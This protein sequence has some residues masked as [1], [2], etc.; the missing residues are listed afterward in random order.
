[1]FDSGENSD[2]IVQCCH[3]TWKLDRLILCAGSDYSKTALQGDRFQVLYP[4]DKFPAYSADV[5]KEGVTGSIRPQEDDPWPTGQLLRF[6]YTHDYQVDIGDCQT[7]DRRCPLSAHARMYAM[8][9][10]HQAPLLKDLAQ[11][12][13]VPVSKGLAITA[14]PYIADAIR[15][16]FTSTLPSDRGLRNTVIPTLIAL[17]QE[18]HDSEDFMSIITWMG[19]TEFYVELMDQWGNFGKHYFYYTHCHYWG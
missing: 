7:D 4:P 2:V 11:E 9:D 6:F 3:R 10:K 17:K 8:A 19:D 12:K 14:I 16:I 13:L 18:L 1:M 5:F 15:I